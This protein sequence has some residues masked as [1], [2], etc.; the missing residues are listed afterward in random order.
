MFI[1]L[2]RKAPGGRTFQVSGRV[3][4]ETYPPLWT[5]LNCEEVASAR[6]SFSVFQECLLSSSGDVRRASA[7]GPTHLT[8]GD[9]QLARRDQAAW[10]A[11]R[12][13]A[14]HLQRTSQPPLPAQRLMTLIKRPS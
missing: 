1:G 7:P 8:P 9:A 13:F 11:E 2:L 14:S 5:F 6:F 12:A 4:V 3:G 10:T